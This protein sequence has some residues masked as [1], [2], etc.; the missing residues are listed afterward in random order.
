M[1]TCY[2]KD[3]QGSRMAGRRERRVLGRTLLWN[4]I[5]D[6]FK[7]TQ[8]LRCMQRI[9][10][11]QGLNT[12][13]LPCCCCLVT[14]LCLTL[15]DPWTIACLASL[16]ATIS[17]S[18]LKIMSIY[19]TECLIKETVTCSKAGEKSVV[20]YLLKENMWVSNKILYS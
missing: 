4:H 16:S 5:T 14:K 17:R 18:L 7:L 9:G 1:L 15:C 8:I 3:F 12:S 19:L 20:L 11:Q 6:I 10:R 13:H 2:Q